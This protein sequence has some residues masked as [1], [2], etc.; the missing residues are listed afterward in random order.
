MRAFLTIPGKPLGKQRPRV[1]KWGTYTPKQTI[2]YETL[3]QQLYITN[4]LPK[5]EG[6]LE[7]KIKAYYPIPKSTSKKNKEKMLKGELLPDKKP[8]LDNIMKIIC[9][10]LNGIA[11]DDDKQIIKGSIYKAYADGPK[12]E[13]EIL[14]MEG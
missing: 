2:N 6:Y 5:L 13:V 1:T 7:V 12:V 11:Y 14:K 10:A 9:D 4:K 3:V 8:D